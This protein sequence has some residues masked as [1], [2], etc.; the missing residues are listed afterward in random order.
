M[1]FFQNPK[2]VDTENSYGMKVM[3]LHGLEGNA[4]GTKGKHLSKEWGALC[5]PLRTA[6]LIEKREDCNGDWDALEQSEKD[7]GLLMAYSDAVSAVRYSQPDL[8]VGSSMGGAILFKLIAEG[9][10]SGAAVFCAPAIENLL[11]PSVVLRGIDR[12]KELQSVWLLAEQ[13][14]LVNNAF[15]VKTAAKCGGSV[16]FSPGDTHRLSKATTQGL[17]D[18]AVLTALEL[19][20]HNDNMLL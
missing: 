15:V 9:K 7:A 4:N 3:F 18:S 2:S 16:V 8:I 17:L 13:D 14:D 6:D 20:V 12:L 11:D 5:P 10:F 19:T 1:S